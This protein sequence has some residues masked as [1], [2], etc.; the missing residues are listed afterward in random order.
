MITKIYS[1]RISICWMLIDGLY[2][3]VFFQLIA[4]KYIIG[5]RIFSKMIITLMK[6]TLK[7]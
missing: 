2:P 6:E 1:L 3:A 5:H 7:A 4:L